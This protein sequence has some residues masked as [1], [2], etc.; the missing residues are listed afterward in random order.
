MVAPRREGR[1]GGGGDDN[2]SSG[3]SNEASYPGRI[4]DPDFC[5]FSRLEHFNVEGSVQVAA[6]WF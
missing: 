1:C 5:A 3:L 6:L 4:L 2:G